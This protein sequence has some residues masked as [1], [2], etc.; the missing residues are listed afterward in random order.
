ML[1]RNPVIGSM[2]GS[3]SCGDGSNCGI[4]LLYP[5]RSG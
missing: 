5:S 1:I 4:C 2:L 3:C